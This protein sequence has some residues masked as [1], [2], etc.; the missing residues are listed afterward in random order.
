MEDIAYNPAVWST[1]FSAQVSAS[2]ALAGLI[3][4]AISINLPKIVVQK[5]LVARSARALATLAG[6]LIAST[7]CLVPAHNR[8]VLGWALI[9]LGV[10]LWA[11]TTFTQHRALSKNPYVGPWARIFHYALAEVS[12]LPFVLAGI[13]LA[14]GRWGGFYWLVVGIIFSFLSALL[15]G[16]V[17][18]IEILR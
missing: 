13:S 3:F 6:V 10:V 2:A 16:W 11:V 12:N 17:L 7:L 9:V 5:P 14:I 8:T 1:F 15:D 4:V 18:L